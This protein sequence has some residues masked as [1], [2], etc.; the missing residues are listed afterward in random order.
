MVSGGGAEETSNQSMLLLLGSW[1][2]AETLTARLLVS[3]V[4]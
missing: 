3:P 2:V 4:R 1:A